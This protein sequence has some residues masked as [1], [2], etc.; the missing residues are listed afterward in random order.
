MLNAIA[1]E[2]VG[3]SNSNI[4]LLV[5]DLRKRIDFRLEQ[6]VDAD[7]AS[8]NLKDPLKYALL[9]PGKRLRPL[10]C[11]ISAQCFGSDIDDAIDPACAIEMIHT[12]SLIIDDLPCMDN[13]Q[14]RRGR[15]ACHARYGEATTILVALEL[16]SLGYRVMSEA[17]NLTNGQRNRLVQ[18]L[19]RAVGLGGLIGG[20][21]S[22]LAAAGKPS[23]DATD[24]HKVM[25]IH[26]LKTGALFVAAG[27]SGCIVAGLKGDQLIPIRDFSAR[28]GLA[29][30][31]FD[32]LLDAHG[33]T[34][35]TG[36]DVGQDADKPTMVGVLGSKAAA[37]YAN[38]MVVAALSALR[39]LGSDMQPLESLIQNMV[40]D[41][42]RKNQTIN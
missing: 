23:P 10:I 39:P 3:R 32:D 25:H 24:S 22:D 36:K 30:Q 34:E 8:N 27:E 19:A 7:A 21:E 42:A 17:P 4:Q 9:A 14:M 40:H 15:P 18:V 20:Q 12:A 11:I 38:N 13:A 31:A 41:P 2:L 16:L 37:D 1:G 26:E 28:L 33:S 6:I 35:E 29:Y 5:D